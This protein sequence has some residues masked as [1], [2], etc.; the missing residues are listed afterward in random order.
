LWLAHLREQVL[1]AKTYSADFQQ[2]QALVSANE[3]AQAHT[4]EMIIAPTS[5]VSENSQSERA[6][7]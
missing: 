6:T 3:H 1:P 7:V 4:C 5:D 2:Y